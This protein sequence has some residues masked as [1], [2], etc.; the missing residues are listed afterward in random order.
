MPIMIGF[1]VLV[2]LQLLWVE[3]LYFCYGTTIPDF[4]QLQGT[5]IYGSQQQMIS[6]AYRVCRELETGAAPRRVPF[7]IPLGH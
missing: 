2:Q 1:Q 7:P 6:L 4:H 3:N 5:S